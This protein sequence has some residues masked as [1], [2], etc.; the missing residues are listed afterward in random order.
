MIMGEISFLVQQ[1]MSDFQS[2]GR[3]YGILLPFFKIPYRLSLET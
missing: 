3:V 1:K 2:N